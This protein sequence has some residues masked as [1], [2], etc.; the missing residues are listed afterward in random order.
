M[1]VTDSAAQQVLVFDRNGTK[2]RAFGPK[3]N[4]E[5]PTGIAIDQARKLVYVSDTASRSRKFRVLVYGLDGIYQRDVGSGTGKENGEFSFQTYLALDKDGNL[6]VADTMNF[7]I[8]VFTPEGVFVRKLE[9][10]GDTPGTFARLKGLAFDGFGNLYAVDSSHEAVRIFNRDFDLLVYF[11]GHAPKMEWMNLPS[12]IAIDRTR[13]RIYVGQE[14]FG[15]VNV[16]DLINTTAADSNP[17]R[18]T[19]DGGTPNP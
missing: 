15:R 11:G 7:R 6:Y 9:K 1:Y 5:R 19:P 17:G 14:S 4:I 13:N 2:L 12:C 8:Q 3:E 16:Y 18:G 10:L